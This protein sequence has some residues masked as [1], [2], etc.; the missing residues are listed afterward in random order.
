MQSTR[1][2]RIR[3]R[4]AAI[5]TIGL[6]SFAGGQAARAAETLTVQIT[7]D[8]MCCAGCAKNVAA[9]LYAAPGVVDVKADIPTRLVT[10]TARPSQKLTLEKLWSAVVKG[11]GGPSKLVAGDFAYTFVPAESV[12]SAER[13]N[14][15]VYRAVIV[16]LTAR[17]AA[18]RVAA[19]LRALRGV[20]QV[21]LDSTP[22]AL[23]IT[24]AAGASLSPWA[25]MGAVQQAKEQ[26]LAIDS[27]LGRMTIERLSTANNVSTHHQ[28]QGTVR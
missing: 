3:F 17:Q 19:T 23:L 9:Q 7:A 1:V 12:A 4:T 6:A 22:D 16:D 21:S 13:L 14:G 27:P 24:P 15:H 10:I 11:K 20:G 28:V 8:A 2:L 26:P 18:D 5:M 25:L